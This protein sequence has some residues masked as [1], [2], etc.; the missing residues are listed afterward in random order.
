[1][2]DNREILERNV[3]VVAKF[4]DEAGNPF[5]MVFVSATAV[6]RIELFGKVIEPKLSLN[7]RKV[8]RTP[9]DFKL[10]FGREDITVSRG[11]DLGAFHLGSTVVLLAPKDTLKFDQAQIGQPIKL[12][13]SIGH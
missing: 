13:E 9:T 1:M 3:R 8:Y 11:E 7:Y 6:S 4:K 2:G 10:F 12:G 5:I